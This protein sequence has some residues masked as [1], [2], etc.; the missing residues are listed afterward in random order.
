MFLIQILKK[1]YVLIILL[2]IISIGAAI[3][4]GFGM[5]LV[6]PFLQGFSGMTGFKVP[7]PFNIVSEIFMGIQLAQRMRLIA[8][9]LFL[10]TVIKG[11]LVYTSIVLSNRLR[12]F[13]V[14][15]LRLKCAKQIMQ[16]DI[17][18]F[19]KQ[20]A[21][22]FYF[23]FDSATE[24]STGAVI[25][26]FGNALPQIFTIL[27]LL[28]FL[29]VL[30]VKLTLLSISLVFFSAFFMGSLTRRVSRAGQL[31]IERRY[32]FNK[33]LFDI[34]NGMKLIRLFNRENHIVNKF[35]NSV[36]EYNAATSTVTKL[37][38]I[39]GP[40]F[41]TFGIGILALIFIFGSFILPSNT[42]AWI[43]ILGTFVIILTRIIN[44]AKSLIQ[45]KTAIAEKMPAVKVLE[46][47]LETSNK[48]YIKN[49]SLK[50]IELKDGLTF[51][52]VTFGYNP[53]DKSVLKDVSFFIPKG[54]RIGIVGRSGSGKSTIIE[55]LL[56]FYD[57]Q[58]G[59]ILIDDISLSDFDLNQWRR[60]IGVVSQDTFLFNDTIKN[61]ISF[62]K[63]EITQSEIEAA[64]KQAHIHDFIC[65]LPN[66]YDT[67]IG[68]RGVLLSGG[69][70]QRISIARAIITSP[71]ILV[72]DEATSSLDTESEQIVQA[73]LN[74]ISK[75]KTL[76]TIAHRLST[77]TASDS[78]IVLDSGKVIDMGRHE[79]LFKRCLLYKKLVELQKL[80]EENGGLSNEL[81]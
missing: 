52:K 34:F 22:D 48:P 33:V 73:A 1:H 37:S 53:K 31:V 45:T 15:D 13:S 21:S 38:G 61:N 19:N 40:L 39:V 54:S 24:S 78:I 71:E 6:F 36:D 4:E 28:G 49:G 32:I 7:F 76:I 25:N 43:G 18:Y 20:R 41:E 81:I 9:L 26:L 62:A 70:R 17:G 57:P 23:I 14:R 69:Q 35:E 58:H 5:T 8:I 64:A 55:L 10:S 11:I 80:E 67:F 79:E 51:D 63:E 42:G 75:E 50:F 59:K 12:V 68:D 2:V 65:S 16:V 44:P 3:F 27:I 72:F 74:D 47:F 56:R 30:S 60:L 77:I 29:F 46:N 66:A